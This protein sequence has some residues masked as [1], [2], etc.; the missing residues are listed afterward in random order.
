MDK[1]RIEKS[2]KTPMVEFNSNGELKIEGRSIPENTVE[3]YT[4]PL[5]W[6]K[7]FANNRPS[8]INLHITLDFFNTSSS[9]LLLDIFKLLEQMQ[10]QR[11]I[12]NV[13]W[14][15]SEDNENMQEA[16]ED[17]KGILKLPFHL[18]KS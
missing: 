13:Y 16:G 7:T 5:N 15:Y 2:I 11:T 6:L 4:I 1:L 17:Y 12:V 8:D 10:K 3:F 14:H 9:K 18:V